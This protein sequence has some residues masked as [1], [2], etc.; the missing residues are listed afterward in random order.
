[1]ITLPFTGPAVAP[2][3]AM[4]FAL[5]LALGRDPHESA[6]PRVMKDAHGYDCNDY[7]YDAVKALRG[8]GR[9]PYYIACRDERGEQHMIAGYATDDGTLY[10]RDNRASLADL[11]LDRLVAHGYRLEL[12]ADQKGLLWYA[13]ADAA[14]APVAP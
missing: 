9:V 2:G 10:A 1:M 8:A 6:R 7:A 13:N 12:A 4:Q 5:W 11:P 3:P 14:S